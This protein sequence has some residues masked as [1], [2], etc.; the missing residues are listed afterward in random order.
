MIFKHISISRPKSVASALLPHSYSIVRG[1]QYDITAFSPNVAMSQI[2]LQLRSTLEEDTNSMDIVN[3]FSQWLN[4]LYTYAS[5][6]RMII[7]IDQYFCGIGLGQYGAA[8]AQE[9]DK[10]LKTRHNERG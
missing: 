5:V 10:Y 4:T 3:G 6:H 1:C 8:V 9:K 7:L 2:N